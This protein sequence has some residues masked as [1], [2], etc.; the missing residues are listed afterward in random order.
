M[1]TRQ[2]S[3]YT[4]QLL[5]TKQKAVWSRRSEIEKDRIKDKISDTLRQ[6]WASIPKIDGE[7]ETNSN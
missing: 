7:Q 3:D 5:S 6:R 4:R 1:Y 2:A